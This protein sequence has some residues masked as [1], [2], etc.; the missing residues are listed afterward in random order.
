MFLV[1]AHVYPLGLPTQM[2]TQ[3]RLRREVKL[4]QA[5]KSHGQLT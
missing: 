5:L 1:T 4:A 2:L 3:I